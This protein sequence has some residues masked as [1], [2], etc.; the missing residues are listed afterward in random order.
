M[1][2]TILLSLCLAISIFCISKVGSNSS[3]QN[4]TLL[5]AAQACVARTECPDGT[6]I[7]CY[8]SVT[9]ISYAMDVTC[10]GN[11]YYCC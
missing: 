6:T 10:D 7:S 11:I 3:I 5:E 9:C 8:G 1:K 2:K 4:W